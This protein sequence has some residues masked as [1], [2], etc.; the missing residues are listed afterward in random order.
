MDFDKTAEI[1]DTYHKLM[2]ATGWPD[3]RENVSGTEF[4]RGWDSTHRRG[5]GVQIQVFNTDVASAG[6]V[7]NWMLGQEFLQTMNIA[8]VGEDS[9]DKPEI[10]THHFIESFDAPVLS[11]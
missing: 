10:D 5:I 3:R 2:E 6:E 9:S 4:D 11:S 1:I 8:E 7:D